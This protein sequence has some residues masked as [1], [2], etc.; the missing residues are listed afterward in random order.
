MN[1]A[2]AGDDLVLPLLDYV[3]KLIETYENK[4]YPV[5]T[6]TPGRML[7]FFMNQHNHKQKDLADIA[8]QSVISEI[9]NEKRVP[10]P[11]QVKRLPAKYHT[12]P[13]VFL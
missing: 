10:T 6:S 2:N 7:A 4:L 11:E 12:D 9:L 13:A 1:R 8:T 3:S 5:D